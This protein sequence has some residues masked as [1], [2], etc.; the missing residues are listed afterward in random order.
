MKR[1]NILNND[2]EVQILCPFCE[3]WEIMSI[4]EQRHH[5]GT[6]DLEWLP[7]EGETEVSLMTCLCKKQFEL[8]WNYGQNPMNEE[9]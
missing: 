2:E 5:I 9:Q 8:T 1:V 6:F 4:D 3:H 7:D